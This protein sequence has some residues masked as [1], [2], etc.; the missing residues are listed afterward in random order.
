MQERGTNKKELN[1]VHQ[2]RKR[3]LHFWWP[4]CEK[5]TNK[6]SILHPARVQAQWKDYQ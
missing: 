6:W 4:W 2:R 5:T 3:L 1:W